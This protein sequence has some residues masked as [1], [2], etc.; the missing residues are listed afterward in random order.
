MAVTWDSIAV[1]FSTKQAKAGRVPVI[2][3]DYEKLLRCWY[4]F[5]AQYIQSIVKSMHDHP[6]YLCCPDVLSLVGDPL[7]GTGVVHR[8]TYSF[9]YFLFYSLFY[10]LN[11]F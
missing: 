4:K 11:L 6:S 8:I 9:D 3:C 1:H 10:L 7:S 2:T 5:V